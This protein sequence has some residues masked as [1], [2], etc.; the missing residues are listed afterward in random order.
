MNDIAFNSSQIISGSSYSSIN[1][2]ILSISGAT[3][4]CLAVEDHNGKLVYAPQTQSG[5]AV[6]IDLS[7]FNIGNSTWHIRFPRGESGSNTS[8]GIGRSEAIMYALIF[9]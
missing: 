7:Q 9:G 1:N 3:V 6:L 2:G 4:G 5:D 8:G